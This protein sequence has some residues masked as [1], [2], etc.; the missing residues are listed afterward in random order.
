[1]NRV[2][3]SPWSPDQKIDASG[4]GPLGGGQATGAQLTGST[5]ATGSSAAPTGTQAS[6]NGATAHLNAQ[7]TIV[8][9]YI[10][11]F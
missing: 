7:P 2:G 6:S 9:N 3:T 1:M 10:I 4:T 8:L 5:D 11:K